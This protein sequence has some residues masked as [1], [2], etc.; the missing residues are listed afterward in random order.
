TASPS[1]EHFPVIFTHRAFVARAGG[2]VEYASDSVKPLDGPI[3]PY[4]T[5][6]GGGLVDRDPGF[7]V[8]EPSHDYVGPRVDSCAQVIDD[9]AQKW[10]DL[11]RGVYFRRAESGHFGLRFPA[12]AFAKQD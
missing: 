8:V 2:R 12:V 9:V 3:D 6:P 11:D 1:L 4:L 10:V 5:G 7:A